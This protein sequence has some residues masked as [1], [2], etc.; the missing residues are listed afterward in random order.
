LYLIRWIECATQIWLPWQFE[1]FCQ[2]F[3]AR[4]DK[5]GGYVD[6]INIVAKKY[7]KTPTSFSFDFVTSLPWSYMDI[8]SYQVDFTPFRTLCQLEAAANLTIIE[9]QRSDNGSPGQECQDGKDVAAVSNSKR[10]LRVIK[11]LRIL[12][13]MRL[14]KGIK[15]VE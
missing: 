9:L 12:K 4:F 8:Y 15:L 3:I 6:D 10:I 7:L 5:S 2:F 13:I 14:L 11:I 1:V